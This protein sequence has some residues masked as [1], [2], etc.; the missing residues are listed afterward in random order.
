VTS[1]VVPDARV[2]RMTRT[3]GSGQQAGATG[4]DEPVLT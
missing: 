2:T 4:V 3:P 1:G